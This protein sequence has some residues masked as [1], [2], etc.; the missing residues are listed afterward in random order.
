MSCIK[1][2][3][4]RD[5]V[6][7]QNRQLFFKKKGELHFYFIL[8]TP[9]FVHFFL[10]CWFVFS[11]SCTRSIEV[12]VCDCLMY[13]VF[14][15]G[16]TFPDPINTPEDLKRLNESV[17]VTKSLKYVSDAITLTRHKLEGKVP[18]IGFA[19]APVSHL[20]L[21]MALVVWTSHKKS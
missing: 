14:P 12:W 18:L 10:F 20:A 7:D 5:A 1:I 15:Q 17:D 2:S 16:P 6:W 9:C 4:K 11:K 13:F 8:C 3:L 19:G 21:C